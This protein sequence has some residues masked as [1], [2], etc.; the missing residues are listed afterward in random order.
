V[1]QVDTRQRRCFY[2]HIGAVVG[3]HAE[4]VALRSF[5]IFHWAVVVRTG[6]CQ[7]AD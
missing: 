6:G 4:L 1:D 7:I 3:P 5:G 2:H